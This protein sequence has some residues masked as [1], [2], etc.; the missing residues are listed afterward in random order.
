MSAI[1]FHMCAG[2]K[3]PTRVGRV[4]LGEELYDCV[5][6]MSGHMTRNLSHR[7]TCGL[8]S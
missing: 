5:F 8:M 7:I 3:I 2:T 4:T 6:N 1:V